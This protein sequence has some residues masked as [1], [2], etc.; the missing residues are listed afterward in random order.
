[1]QLVMLQY[2]IPGV[3]AEMN[4][5]DNPVPP[6]PNPSGFL[7][8]RA[9][10]L[11]LSVW[12]FD[13]DRTPWQLIRDMDQW[14]QIYAGRDMP[15]GGVVKTIRY[16]VHDFSPDATEGILKQA[17]QV[18]REDLERDKKA[19]ATAL[20]TA[21]ET[22][23]EAN[24]AHDAGEITWQERDKA[25]LKY[26]S[27]RKTILK[28]TEKLVSDLELAAKSFGMDWAGI[29]SSQ[30]LTSARAEVYTQGAEAL[31]PN[32]PASRAAIE[33]VLPPE[34]LADALEDQG[35]DTRSIRATFTPPVPN[36]NGN[37]TP[38]AVQAPVEVTTNKSMHYDAVQEV[39]IGEASS[40]GLPAGDFPLRL[41]VKSHRTG[42][43]K[44]FKQTKVTYSKDGE[45]KVVAVNYETDDGG[46]LRI[47]ND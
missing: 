41:N 25:R 39:L 12:A 18:M 47:L 38:V 27:Y 24:R 21:L 40:L 34:I 5:G 8:R 9:L 37:G 20:A 2:D 22:L 26:K 23:T 33:A 35:E 14:S 17:A 10:R 13:K 42:I 46:R 15:N 7:R 28:R 36:R 11:T 31:A 45:N 29:R 6:F 1:M 44:L 43:T 16:H 3:P 30:A 32:A 19:Q 4:R